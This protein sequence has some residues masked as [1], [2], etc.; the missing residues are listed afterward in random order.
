M[1]AELAPVTGKQAKNRSNPA[2]TTLMVRACVIRDG[3]PGISLSMDREVIGEW[4]D[5]RAKTLS[6]TD[7]C[8]VAIQGVDGKLLYL[9]STPGKLVSGEQVSDT[10]VTITFD[11]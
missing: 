4:T 10:E 2:R 9:F 3:T 6:L 7:D 8:K 5:S 1:R 11:L